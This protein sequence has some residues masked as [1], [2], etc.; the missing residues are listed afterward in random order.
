L[1]GTSILLLTGTAAC[2][3]IGIVSLSVR[4]GG[5]G[6]AA[7][8]AG[9]ILAGL[10]LFSVG[11]IRVSPSESV[12]LGRARAAAALAAMVP[13]PWTLAAVSLGRDTGRRTLR[14]W[15]PYLAL[16]AALTVFFAVRAYAPGLIFGLTRARDGYLIALGPM[17]RALAI[18][19]I[20]SLLVVL[21]HIEATVRSAHRRS[22]RRI[23]YWA[24][25]LGAAFGYHVFVA[26]AALLYSMVR[27][28]LLVAGSVPVLAAA[29]LSGY[30]VVTRRLDDTRVRVGRPV[31]YN[32]VTALLSGVYLV[33]LGLFGAAARS[34]GWSLPTTVTVSIIFVALLVLSLFLASDRVR[35][36][37]RRFVDSNLYVSRYDYRREW[38]GASRMFASELSEA[39]VASRIEDFVAETLDASSTRVAPIERDE[40]GACLVRSGEGDL[41]AALGDGELLD[42]FRGSVEAARVDS[43]DAEPALRAWT[44]RHTD[45]F[46]R[47]SWALLGPLIAGGELVGAILVGARRAGRYTSEDLDLLATVGL[48][49]GN[50]IL[51]ARLAERVAAASGMESIHRLTSFWLHDLKNCASGLSLAL[52]NAREKI[53]DPGF[54]TDLLEVLEGSV[55]SLRTIIDRTAAARPR[56]EIRPESVGIREIVEESLAKAGLRNGSSGMEVSLSVENGLAVEGDR[57]LLGAMLRNLI[58]NAVEAVGERGRIEVAGLPADEDSVIV[59]VADDGPGISPD[60]LDHGRIFAPFVTSKA[61]GVGLGLYQC[62]VIAEAHGGRIEARN[63]GG[64]VFEIHLP[65]SAGTGSGATPGGMRERRPVS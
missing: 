12:A 32:S 59:R 42:R 24:I 10:W 2:L 3:V 25:G 5:G 6:R 8:G 36:S 51:A 27:V 35:R 29:L 17:G 22:V 64:A 52:T 15:A 9:A 37:I 4:S 57:A 60:L 56:L 58:A 61:D 16:L 38:A 63:A 33:A 49:A 40:A 34:R 50:A 41:D 39:E 44:R 18:Y 11:S 28:P 19:L 53:G 48:Q 47:G 13:F 43:E 45:V 30:A 14:R 54:Q 46:G 23:K 20:G 55:S 1:D 26:S 31:F 7:F 62:R 65:A 21:F